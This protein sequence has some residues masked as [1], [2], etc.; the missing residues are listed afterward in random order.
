[1]IPILLC[2]WK[3]LEIQLCGSNLQKLKTS[4]KLLPGKSLCTKFTWHLFPRDLQTQFMHYH[5]AISFFNRNAC[6][7]TVAH[8]FSVQTFTNRKWFC[9]SIS[10]T[11]VL[12]WYL[13][14]FNY[15]IRTECSSA[16]ILVVQS[17]NLTYM[18]RKI[19]HLWTCWKLD[20]C[21]S[22]SKKKWGK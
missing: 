18:L 2:S 19:S 11:M 3:W 15:N 4:W 6:T 17:G 12:T 14:V 10:K 9:V 22:L 21:S 5:K 7:Y 16:A 1:M 20:E 8:R 13:K